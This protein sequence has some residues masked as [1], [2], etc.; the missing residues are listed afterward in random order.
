MCCLC[1]IGAMGENDYTALCLKI[2]D[3][4]AMHISVCLSVSLSVSH[5][6]ICG[7][8]EYGGISCFF[9]VCTHACV[10]LKVCL[11]LKLTAR[12]QQHILL[13]FLMFLWSKLMFLN[14]VEG[15][16]GCRYL[17]VVIQL[18]YRLTLPSDELFIP[19]T[20]RWCGGYS[21]HD[22]YPVMSCS[23]QVPPGGVEVTADVQIDIPLWCAFDCR[24]LQV[25]RRLQ[26]MYKL[27]FP[28]DVLLIP[29]TSRQCGG[30]SSC[31]NWHS[32][33]MHSWCQV[34]PGGV[35][36]TPDVQ[37]DIPQWC[38]FDCRY[39]QVERRLQ[40]MYKPDLFTPTVLP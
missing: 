18:T 16:V 20:S 30:Y 7:L 6:E 3:R 5:L 31:T 25:V 26:L 10:P 24:Y 32:P 40:L 2:F 38:A 36:V 9:L 27:T 35:E 37:T 1:K 13:K 21:W 4:W 12:V 34:P 29:C 28:S 22:C 15:S 19:G 23:F 11:F 39:L 17:Q 14:T 33:V 8:D